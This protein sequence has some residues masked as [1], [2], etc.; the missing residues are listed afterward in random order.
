MTLLCRAIGLSGLLLGPYLCF[1]QNGAVHPAALPT[2]A[3]V[4]SDSPAINPVCANNWSNDRTY[5]RR[6]TFGDFADLYVFGDHKDGVAIVSGTNLIACDQI[7]DGEIE[8]W[9]SRNIAVIRHGRNQ[10]MATVYGFGAGQIVIC[11]YPGLDT[12][13]L[14]RFRKADDAEI[15]VGKRKDM[16][17]DIC[18]DGHQ[19]HK[20]WL[21]EKPCNRPVPLF[22][23]VTRDNDNS[24]SPRI[25]A[26]R[27]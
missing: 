3:T 13:L 1:G 7:N 2:K 8:T 5:V 10:D 14:V 12:N 20:S 11:D 27:P 16:P 21:R 9:M 4:R 25:I 17:R 23:D 6:G 15:T 26:G 18:W 19:F 24:N 22:K